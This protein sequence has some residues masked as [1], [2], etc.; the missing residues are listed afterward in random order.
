[1]LEPYTGIVHLV[2][3]GNI[4]FYQNWDSVQWARS[5]DKSM[6][7]EISGSTISM[8]QSPFVRGSGHLVLAIDS[9]IL[10]YQSYAQHDLKKTED[11]VCH[12][13]NFQSAVIGR[14]K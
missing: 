11:G 6:T 7:L 13:Q 10:S 5:S 4:I 2:A 9:H 1:M 3:G 8:I 12:V 14:C